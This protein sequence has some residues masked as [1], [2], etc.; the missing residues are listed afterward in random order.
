MPNNHLIDN[1]SPNS[2][3]LRKA[4]EMKFD[5]VFETLAVADDV[6]PLKDFTNSVHIMAL[7]TN[8]S[9]KENILVAITIDWQMSLSLKTF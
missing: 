4:V 9:I 2:K 5:P 8:T 1:V 7:K 3:Q 6:E